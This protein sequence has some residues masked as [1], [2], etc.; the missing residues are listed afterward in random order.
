MR[1][2][3]SV[4]AGAL[5]VLFGGCGGGVQ[6]SSRPDCEA[7]KTVLDGVCVSAAVA[8]YVSCVRAQGAQLSSDQRESL[9]AEVGYLAIKAQ[10]ASD[11][12]DSLEKKYSVSDEATLEIIRTCKAIA[13]AGRSAVARTSDPSNARTLVKFDFERRKLGALPATFKGDRMS[14]LSCSIEGSALECNGAGID[15]TKGEWD[16]SPAI[17]HVSD[18]FEVE[19]HVRHTDLSA[20]AAFNLGI[21]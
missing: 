3:E 1:S 13:G 14:R 12:S 4:M 21:C 11:V 6:S 5:L 18:D 7:G 10:A 2:L 19:V 17:T 15:G 9:S 16:L 20:R 8:D